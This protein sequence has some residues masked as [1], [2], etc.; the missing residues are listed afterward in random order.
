MSL[1]FGLQEGKKHSVG[2]PPTKRGLRGFSARMLCCEKESCCG[3][4]S[5]GAVGKG[6]GRPHRG[7]DLG[8]LW[9]PP[10]SPSLE[11]C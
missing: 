1:L 4:P 7:Q 3:N 5:E 10:H 2:L 8:H 9:D 6:M 11:P